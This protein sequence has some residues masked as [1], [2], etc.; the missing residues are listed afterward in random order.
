MLKKLIRKFIAI[1][2]ELAIAIFFTIIILLITYFAIGDVATDVLSLTK[3]LERNFNEKAKKTE[4]TYNAE[5]KSLVKYPAWGEQ[6]ATLTIKS[7]QRYDLPV[8]HG[9]TLDIIKNGVG[10]N[11][12]TYFPGEGGSIVLGAHNSVR[13]FY[14]LPQV[15]IGDTISIKTSY[16]IFD[17]DVY[18]TDIIQE[19]D[20]SKLPIQSDEEI[21]M[22]YT[23][24][25]VGGIGYRDKRYVVYARLVLVEQVGDN[26][27]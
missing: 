18:D 10:H 16:G 8:Y 5:T 2:Q 13:D 11:A 24:Y 15:K 7:I 21:L 12:G 20:E 17:Y 6:F 9:D 14:Y 27:G 1:A 3:I 4:I 25:P 23:C 19:K 22:L 26:N